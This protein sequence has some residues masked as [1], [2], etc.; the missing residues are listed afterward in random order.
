MSSKSQFSLIIEKTHF[1]LR[2]LMIIV[3]HQHSLALVQLLPQ[4][5]NKQS[6][7]AMVAPHGSLSVGKL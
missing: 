7:S 3:I 2:A 5:A 1:S 6:W 4:Q